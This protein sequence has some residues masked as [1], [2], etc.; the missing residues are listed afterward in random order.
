MNR[1]NHYVIQPDPGS[2]QTDFFI[3]SSERQQAQLCLKESIW[4][5]DNSPAPEIKHIPGNNQH[6]MH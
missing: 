5:N 2:C 3:S 1:L 4:K 6:E